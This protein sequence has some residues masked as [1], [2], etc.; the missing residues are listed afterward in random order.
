MLWRIRK[1]CRK[2]IEFFLTKI[3]L[4]WEQKVFV[5]ENVKVK[6]MLKR[7]DGAECLAIVFS[8]CTR[9]G[10][11]ARYNYV[12]TLNGSKCNRLYILDDYAED[13][14]GSYYLGN[15]FTF[16][17]ERATDALIKKIISETNPQKI[18]FCGSSKGG[19]AALNFGLEYPDA[20]IIAG[21]PQYFLAAYLRQGNIKTL[22]HIEGECSE[23]KDKIL[24]MRLREKIQAAK[25][26]T[27]CRVFLHYS[28]REHT[29]DEHVKYLVKDLEDNGYQVEKDISDYENHGDISLY[30]PDFLKKKLQLVMSEQRD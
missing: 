6:Y 9:P 25:N 19:Y 29:Y 23:E 12:K 13:H 10:L 30:F 4:I 7:S 17:E 11:K 16:V 1:V 22:E 3:M 18:V 26:K 5:H 2:Y 15:Q 8:A 20:Y 27:T 28:D 21:A 24:N 14:R